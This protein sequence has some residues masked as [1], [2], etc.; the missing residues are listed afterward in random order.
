M[1]CLNVTKENIDELLVSGKPLLLDFWAPWCGPCKQIAPVVEG[2]SIE[3]DDILVC[4]V[5][6]DDEITLAQRYRVLSIPTLIVLK[7]GQV[8]GKAVGYRTRDEILAL[9]SE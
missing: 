1:A 3:R 5:N 6:V 7:G 8:T 2:I 4:K 9:I